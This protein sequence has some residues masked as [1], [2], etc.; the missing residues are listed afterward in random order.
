MLKIVSLSFTLPI[1]IALM[2]FGGLSDPQDVS[3]STVKSFAE[4]LAEEKGRVDS[5]YGGG[6]TEPADLVVDPRQMTRSEYMQ[7]RAR[8][9]ETSGITRHISRLVSGEQAVI[10]VEPSLSR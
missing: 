9:N 3:L 7:F 4:Y 5:W 2:C 10:R 8:S 6:K 1:L